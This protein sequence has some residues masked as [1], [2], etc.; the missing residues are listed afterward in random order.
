MGKDEEENRSCELGKGGQAGEARFPP[1][2]PP[3][4]R[5]CLGD[6]GSSKEGGWT[7]SLPVRKHVSPCCRIRGKVQ[8][9]NVRD[10]HVST[11]QKHCSH[12]SRGHQVP[13][14]VVTPDRQPNHKPGEEPS[15]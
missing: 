8:E 10:A 13:L 1:P 14:A 15:Q 5:C 6:S 3:G 9:E 7:Q 11:H 12:L 2:E 4:P